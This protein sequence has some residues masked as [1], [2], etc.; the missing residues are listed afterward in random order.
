MMWKHTE[1]WV[2]WISAEGW[3]SGSRS[4]KDSAMFSGLVKV[5]NLIIITGWCA[6]WPRNYF[7]LRKLKN[8]WTHYEVVRRFSMFEFS[9]LWQLQGLDWSKAIDPPSPAGMRADLTAVSVSQTH[10]TC[11]LTKRRANNSC[12]WIFWNPTVATCTTVGLFFNSS[13]THKR[14]KAG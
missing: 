4:L 9:L 14:A 3:S 5:S 12:L 6:L 7:Y 2:H 8:P 1:Q 10:F 13:S 11:L